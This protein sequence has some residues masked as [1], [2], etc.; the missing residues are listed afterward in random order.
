MTLPVFLLCFQTEAKFARDLPN[1]ISQ[2]WGSLSR[3]HDKTLIRAPASNRVDKKQA[4]AELAQA[5]VKLGLEFTIIF[6][7]F[8]FSRFGFVELVRW[9]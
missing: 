7:R 8:G 1:P 5:Q 2:G 6:C 4:E 3:T 9:I